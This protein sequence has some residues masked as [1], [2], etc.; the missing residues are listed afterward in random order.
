MLSCFAKFLP[1]T[2]FVGGA[3]EDLFASRKWNRCILWDFD[4]WFGQKCKLNVTKF[5]ENC[6]NSDVHWHSW[7][8]FSVEIVSRE[9]ELK[10]IIAKIQLKTVWHA[11]RSGLKTGRKNSVR[12]LQYI[13]R[14]WFI[15]RM[16]SK[17]GCV[18]GSV[19]LS[20]YKTL[21]AEPKGS[22]RG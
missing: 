13:P 20:G 16:Y 8:K 22:C 6:Q 2:N 5:C 12:N 21:C 7:F 18:M 9:T 15:W 1:A 14:T 3:S 4:T 11:L 17:F 10:H 19:I